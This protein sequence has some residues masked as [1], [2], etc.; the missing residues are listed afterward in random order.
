MPHLV[1]IR[2]MISGLEKKS[3]WTI[4]LNNVSIKKTAIFL[5]VIPIFCLNT[6]KTGLLTSCDQEISG[7]LDR[8]R[9]TGIT[10]GVY[11][12]PVVRSKLREPKSR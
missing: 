7:F 2:G 5:I 12:L 11:A 1:R 4:C 9:D 10:A 3:V 8:N 6:A